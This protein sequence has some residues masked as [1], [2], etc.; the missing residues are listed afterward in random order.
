MI[1]APPSN[2]QKRLIWARY[3]E[4]QPVRVPVTLA[5]NPR[6]ILL[7]PSLNDAGYTFEDAAC[8]P[9][10][11]VEVGLRFQHYV[12]TVLNHVTDGP[13]DLPDVW[14]VSLHTYN[15]YEAAYF[16]A[17]VCFP[18]GQ[19]PATEPILTDSGDEAMFAV[20]VEH[21]LEN[22]YIRRMLVFWDEMDRVCRDMVWQGRPV[23]LMP[24]AP[25]GSD[26]ALTVACN[27]RGGDFL[28]DLLDQPETAQ[29][30]LSRITEAAIHRRRA[31]EQ[32]WGDRISRGNGLADDSCIMLSE[33]QY[34]RHIMPRHRRFYDAQPG[35]ARGTSFSI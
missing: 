2:E 1:S 15:V 33:P 11:H 26:G 4:R 34:R 7:D 3:R 35:V 16:G 24:W 10:I 14:Q 6:I 9:V 22:P 18:T 31:F 19:V 8:D 13:T 29:R 12:R 28:L 32:Y 5:C 23:Q 21:P 27:L 25:T 20:D 30:L 17:E